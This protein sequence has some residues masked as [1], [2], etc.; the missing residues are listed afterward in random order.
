MRFDTLQGWLRWQETL[1]PRSI[2][3]GLDRVRRTAA[4]L[5]LDRPPFRVITVG[6]TNGKGSVSTYAAAM[7]QAAGISTGRYL[8]PHLLRYNERIAVDGV[9]VEDAELC[10][11]FAAVDKARGGDALTYFEFGTLAALEVFRRRKVEAAVLEVGLGGRLDAVNVLDADVA[12]VVSVGI[13]HTEWLGGTIPEIARE[14]AG[15]FRSGSPAICAMAQPP[16]ALLD[17]ARRIGARLRLAGRDYT[18]RQQVDTWR[19]SNADRAID[20]LPLPMPGTHQLGNASAAIAAVIALQP[21]LPDAAVATGLAARLPGRLQSLGGSPEVILDVGHNRDAA[22]AIAAWLKP[23]SRRVE[24][25]LGMLSDKDAGAFASELAPVVHGWHTVSLEGPRGQEAK[26]L[27]ERLQA[28]DVAAL[29]H[30]SMR[31]A[32]EAACAAAGREGRVLVTGSFHTVEAFLLYWRGRD[33][34]LKA[35]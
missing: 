29:A 6:G 9:E 23:G 16:A 24:V 11:G 34:Q 27:R 21:E 17:E 15:I 20:D 1:N 10:D 25:V 2:D 19:W 12:V 22:A 32:F 33:A 26:A 8:S 14:K 3:L 28:A 4:R 18:W 35:R 30:G 5:G 7:L 13:D 31:D